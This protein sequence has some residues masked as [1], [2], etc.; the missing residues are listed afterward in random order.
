MFTHWPQR[1]THHCMCPHSP[2]G[3]EH[4]PHN[5][6][7]LIFQWVCVS[8]SSILVSSVSTSLFLSS[9]FS[10]CNHSSSPLFQFV[11]SA[12]FVLFPPPSFSNFH[13]LPASAEA[14]N[15][16]LVQSK[17]IS[18]N[19]VNDI[20]AITTHDTNINAFSRGTKFKLHN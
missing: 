9:P 15:A 13:S 16:M 5:V 19:C 6:R 10:V 1:S 18:E 8:F 11:L 12:L 4:Q 7:H 2:L 14:E 17:T 20:S 3:G